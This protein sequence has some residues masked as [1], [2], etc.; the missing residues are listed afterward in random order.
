[1]S[2]PVLEV[3]NLSVTFR[4]GGRTV[5]ALRDVSLAIRGGEVLAL[6]GE[7]GSGK[8]TL[9]RTV[10]GIVAPSAGQVLFQGSDLATAS[11]VRALRRRIQMVF[12]DPD[13]SLNPLH[14]ARTIVA[15]PMIVAGAPGRDAIARRV[16]E[17]AGLVHLEPALLDRRP[18]QLSGGQ[19]Q[20]VAI[21][22]ALAVSPELLIADEALS[23]LDVS[24]QAS[25]AALFRDVREQLGITLLFI[26][27]DLATVRQ[28]ATHVAVM[29]AG[30]IVEYGPCAAVIDAPAHPYTQLLVAATPDPGRR[31]LDTALVE[32]IDALP[33][34]PQDEAACRYRPRCLGRQEACARGP[35]LE[36][37]AGAT[38]H[39]A[40]CH[41]RDGPGRESL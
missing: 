26:S 18:R 16:L 2:A 33:T 21:A 7:S 5:H 39:L 8:S 28:L 6:V 22:R 36:A 19:K 40:R 35:R 38:H 31:S 13:S 9:A 25:I 4:S 41:F 11:D 32:R 37:L 17:L 1:M 12:Q 27:H 10:A 23:A 3:R 29:F 34:L 14:R 24:T 15:E 20:R 30:D